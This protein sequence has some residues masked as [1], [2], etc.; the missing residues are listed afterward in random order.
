[1]TLRAGGDFIRK[2]FCRADGFLQAGL[3]EAL[4]ARRTVGGWLHAQRPHRVIVNSVAQSGDGRNCFSCPGSK[5]SAE[6]CPAFQIRRQWPPRVHWLAQ[7]LAPNES[8]RPLYFRLIEDKVSLGPN[9][10][11]QDW[12]RLQKAVGQAGEEFCV[13]WPHLMTSCDPM[14]R[15][16]QNEAPPSF[17]KTFSKSIVS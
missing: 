17:S 1:M 15:H 16:A 8:E 10:C 3:G 9:G 11:R 13:L 4:C 7:I 5:A 14:C 12:T 6:V 2:T